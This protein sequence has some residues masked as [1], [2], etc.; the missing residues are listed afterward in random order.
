M[1]PKLL[2]IVGPTASGKSALALSLAK[3]FGGELVSADSRQMYREMDVGT[4]KLKPPRGVV[5][6]MTDVVAPNKTYSVQQYQRAA[7][8]VI[9]DIQRR[10]KLPI[11]VGGTGFYIDAVV[12]GWKLP[13]VRPSKKLRNELERELREKGLS[14]LVQ[15]LKNVDRAAYDRIDVQNPRR[16]MRALELALSGIGRQEIQ[17]TFPYDVLRIGVDV[18]PDVLRERLRKRTVAMWKAGLVREAKQLYK[19]YPKAESVRTGIGYEEAIAFAHSELSKEEAI[20]KIVIRSAQ[21]ARR[22]RTWWRRD[23]R[24]VW[25]TAIEEAEPAVL[26]WLEKNQESRSKN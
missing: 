13:R 10:G 21:Y 11:L 3:R 5:Q 8:K 25:I 4:A 20:E 2:V 18:A 7:T 26:L 24:I 15:H 19:K 9:R 1:K 22:Q 12:D 23:K 16:V 17:K 14:S 6:W